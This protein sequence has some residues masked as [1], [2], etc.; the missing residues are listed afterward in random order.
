MPGV[1][2]FTLCDATRSVSFCPFNWSRP[3]RPF[4]PV[5]PV[6]PVLS[7]SAAGVV[8]PRVTAL[9]TG[10]CLR[11]PHA[12]VTSSHLIPSSSLSLGL[13]HSR[14][15]FRRLTLCRLCCLFSCSLW[16]GSLPSR[17]RTPW[18]GVLPFSSCRPVPAARFRSGSTDGKEGRVVGKIGK[19]SVI[20]KSVNP[21][22]SASAGWRLLIG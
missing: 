14:R 4:R 1:W 8:L 16:T 6:Q 2:F 18:A 20:S 22:R 15:F 5:L 21:G 3:F 7:R 10:R 17:L 11:H 19:L 12:F 13:L 9:R